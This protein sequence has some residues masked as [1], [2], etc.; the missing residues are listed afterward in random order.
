MAAA[1]LVREFIDE[2]KE[3]PATLADAHEL[4]SGALAARDE[5]DSILARHAKHWDMSRLALVDRNIL[6]LAAAELL[7][8]QTPPKVVISE[9]IRLA[10]EFSTADSGRFVNGVIDAVLKELQ[11]D[12]PADDAAS[13]NPQ[14]SIRNP[15]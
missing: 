2:S 9:A 5:A 8:R 13:A 12:D 14:S 6:R 11:A 4:L 15:Q 3:Q 1:D 7:D 10:R